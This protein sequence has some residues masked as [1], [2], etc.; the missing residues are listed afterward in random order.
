MRSIVYVS[1]VLAASA[2]LAYADSKP[3]FSADAL[4]LFNEISNSYDLNG[5]RVASGKLD[6]EVLARLAKSKEKEVGELAES[7]VHLKLLQRL[8]REDNKKVQAAFEEQAKRIPGI[9][10]VHVIDAL[11]SPEKEKNDL[12]SAAKFLEELMG[13]KG[14]RKDSPQQ[15]VNRAWSTACLGNG[16]GISM[17]ESMRTLANRPGPA[18]AELKN[19]I[20]VQVN[21]E[22]LGA[23]TLTNRTDH[24][25]HHCLIFTRLEA[26]KDRL[27]KLAAEEDLVGA[28][29]LPSLGFSKNTVEASRLAAQLRWDFNQQDKGVM[30]YV[31]EIPARGTVTSQLARPDYYTIS[32]GADMSIW[33]DELTLDHQPADNWSDARAA[34]E[35]TLKRPTPKK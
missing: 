34:V 5:K 20:G 1:A 2:S 35:K 12:Q 13:S 6:E 26:D 4:A 3:R 23:I 18:T 15:A 9:V 24:A 30:L 16:L 33:C 27:K 31:P 28:L 17:R 10:A 25:L 32:K 7:A 19:P 8:S 21:T 29:I 22:L 11:R 14:G